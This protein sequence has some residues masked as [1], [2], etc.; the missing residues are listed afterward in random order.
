MHRPP[1]R[2][3]GVTRTERTPSTRR[4]A[5]A[6]S[7]I[8]LLVVVGLIVLLVGG[9]GLALGGRG[10]EGAALTN[11]QNI[12][13]GLVGAARAQAALHQTRVRLAIYAQMPPA[14]NADASK[15]LRSLILLREDPVD[16]GRYVAAGDPVTLPAP[17]CVVPPA[18]VPSNHLRS[19]VTWNNN[20]QLGPVSTLTALNGFSYR[21]QS[22]ANSTQFF[23]VNGRNGR[24]LYLDFTSDGTVARPAAIPPNTPI[25]IALTTAVLGGNE[26]PKFNSA[27][28]VRGLFIRRTGAVSLVDTATGF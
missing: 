7:L 13:A 10:G 1:R 12:M 2:I 23:G 19:G 21:G 27:N 18:P 4:N 17:I 6:F 11:A 5:R 9:V 22:A 20:V 16:S 26:L 14:A 3:D 25:K 28:T 8:E 15:Y 24:I